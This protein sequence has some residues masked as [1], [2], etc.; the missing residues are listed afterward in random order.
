MLAERGAN[1][2]GGWS[3]P[4]VVEHPAGTC[5]RKAEAKSMLREAASSA[6]SPK[7]TSE[8]YVPS[9]QQEGTLPTHCCSGRRWRRKGAPSVEMLPAREQGPWARRN[10]EKVF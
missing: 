2:S 1:K 5:D 3:C 10:A 7:V 6:R 9:D 8:R 4:C